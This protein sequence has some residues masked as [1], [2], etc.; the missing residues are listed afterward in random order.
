MNALSRRVTTCRLI[1][2][3]QQYPEQSN[4]LS[5]EN[6]SYVNEKKHNGR[7]KGEK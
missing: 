5:L 6:K 2:K 3:M 7:M 4:R 1:C